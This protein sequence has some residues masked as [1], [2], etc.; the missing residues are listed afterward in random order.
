MCDFVAMAGLPLQSMKCLRISIKMTGLNISDVY[1][2]RD[3]KSY[4]SRYVRIIQNKLP[5]CYSDLFDMHTRLII[6]LLLKSSYP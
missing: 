4:K 5:S 1:S 3:C 6:L 2:P